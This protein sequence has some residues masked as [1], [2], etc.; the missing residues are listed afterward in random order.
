MVNNKPQINAEAAKVPVLRA[1]CDPSLKDDFKRRRKESGFRSQTDAI[2]TLARDFVSG[3]IQYRGG[4]LVSQEKSS[5]PGNTQGR[6][7]LV[8]ART[9]ANVKI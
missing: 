6:E 3:R 8:L 4:R 2:L 1:E 7:G 9:E 5:H